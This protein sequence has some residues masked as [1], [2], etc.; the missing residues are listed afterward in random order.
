M[1][2]RAPAWPCVCKHMGA[3]A[4]LGDGRAIKAYG[5]AWAIGHFNEPASRATRGGR[6][7]PFAGIEGTRQEL[8]RWAA[9]YPSPYRRKE[10]R[11]RGDGRDGRGYQMRATRN[12]NPFDRAGHR[13]TC[14]CSLLLKSFVARGI[15]LLSL[16]LC[17]E[18]REK[19][20]E[21]STSTWQVPL[22]AL[23]SS[24]S[25]ICLNPFAATT[26]WGGY[27][28]VVGVCVGV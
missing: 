10:S 25:F 20:R 12:T 11:S 22:L 27:L 13:S 19:E 4:P 9:L 7:L 24:S 16:R 21:A 18:L 17:Y 28:V 23:C 2:L 26:F 6:S 3:K 14:R 1:A 8:G 15:F 5:L